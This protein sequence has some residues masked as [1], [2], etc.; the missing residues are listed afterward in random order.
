MVFFARSWVLKMEKMITPVFDW[1]PASKASQWP[2]G[3]LLRTSLRKR[4]PDERQCSCA[5]SWPT[6]SVGCWTLVE[7]DSF[8]CL[9]GKTL[10]AEGLAQSKLSPLSTNDRHPEISKEL[11]LFYD[12]VFISFQFPSRLE[13]I[14]GFL[15]IFSLSHLTYSNSFCFLFAEN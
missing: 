3:S 4:C 5:S 9:Q 15:S 6:P 11:E 12:R 13:T 14:R 7:I 2:P 10:V 1:G 8:Q